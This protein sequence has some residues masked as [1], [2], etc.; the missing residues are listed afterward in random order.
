MT[1]A[2][3]VEPHKLDCVECALIDMDGVI[4][5]GTEVLPGARELFHQLHVR[6]LKYSLVTN[7]ATLTPAQYVEKLAGMGI[8]VPESTVFTSAMAT[9]LYLK[10]IAPEG[11]PVYIIGESGLSRALIDAG[12]WVDEEHPRYVCVGLDRQL[13][14]ESLAVATL[15]IRA[16]AGFIATNP[17]TTLPTERGVVPGVGSILAALV[18][19]TGVRPRVIGKPEPDMFEMCVN[20]HR[21]SKERTVVIGD[22]LETD[23][24]AGARAGL[25]TTLVLTG[26]SRL[27]E[28]ADSPYQ[29]SLIVEDLSQFISLLDQS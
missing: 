28:V 18:A 21:V 24:A 19:A 11:A 16:G 10:K 14:Y 2:S 20:R 1:G 8:Q 13:T 29:P 25:F 26:I 23:I 27:D 3:I 5:V 22:R 17:D 15:A 6:G 12:F 9:S 4:Y 7:N